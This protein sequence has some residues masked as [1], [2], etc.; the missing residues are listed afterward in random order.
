MFDWRPRTQGATVYVTSSSAEKI[1]RAIA[2]GAKAGF[3]YKDGMRD[4]SS[5]SQAQ[6]RSLNSIE[7]WAKQLGTDLK[8][9]GAMLNSVIDGSG[10]DILTQTSSILKH[11][12]RV[13]V[14]GT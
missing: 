9:E 14:Y 7:D 12:G 5:Q 11:G 10:G 3:N 1:K 2:L 6:P 13:V 8:K 4:T